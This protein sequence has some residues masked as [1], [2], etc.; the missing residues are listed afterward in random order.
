[1]QPPSLAFR[2]LS[3]GYNHAMAKHS[4]HILELARKGAEARL[5]ELVDE[6]R[7]LVSSFPH[8]RDSFDADELPIKFRLRSAAERPERRAVRRR[9]KWSAAQRKAVSARMK[10]YWAARRRAKR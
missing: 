3:L 1:M 9:A 10:K 5:R 2:T 6:A 7:K 8:L 4:S